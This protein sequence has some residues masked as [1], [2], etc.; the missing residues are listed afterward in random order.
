MPNSTGKPRI[1]IF[2]AILVGMLVLVCFAVIVAAGLARLNGQE[3]PTPVKEPVSLGYCG[4]EFIDLCVAS[5]GRDV[6]GNTIVNMYVPL[7]KYPAFYLNIVRQSGVGRYECSWNKNVRT[8]VF[9][10]GGTIGLGEGFEIQMFSI[11]GD[12]LL[13]KGTFTLT[14]ILVPT[15]VLESVS[16]TETAIANA[17]SSAAAETQ[18]AAT[19]KATMTK[20]PSTPTPFDFSTSTSTPFDIF[21]LDTATPTPS[22]GTT[23]GYP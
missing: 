4:A 6:Y 17:T 9:C 15:P 20:T 10:T 14:A 12:R 18:T 23:P 22:A 5:F 19:S 2:A 1:F 3:T 8:S 11:K 21:I 16:L 7:I 13:A